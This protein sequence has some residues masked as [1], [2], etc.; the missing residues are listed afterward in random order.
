M[1]CWIPHHRH[2][3]FNHPFLNYARIISSPCTTFSSGCTSNIC[4]PSAAHIGQTNQAFGAPSASWMNEYAVQP[5]TRLFNGL[6]GMSDDRQLARHFSAD[7]TSDRFVSAASRPGRR[8]YTFKAHYSTTGD[9]SMR[10][11]SDWPPS[12]CSPAPCSTFCAS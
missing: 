8:G 10:S 9:V 3:T 5:A 7:L 2:L 11:P 6:K 4:L 12:F 1:L